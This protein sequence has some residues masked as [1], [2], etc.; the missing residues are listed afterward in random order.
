V[1]ELLEQGVVNGRTMNNTINIKSLTTEA[2]LELSTEVK[3]VQ[4]TNKNDYWYVSLFKSK[5][6]L[7]FRSI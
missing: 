5:L 1:W 3:K 6:A 7:P 4:Y 2:F